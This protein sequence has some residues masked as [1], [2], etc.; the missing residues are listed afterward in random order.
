MNKLDKAIKNAML[1]YPTVYPTRE[2]FLS[3]VFLVIGNGYDWNN[4][5]LVSYGDIR[6]FKNR[7]EFVSDI[8]KRITHAIEQSDKRIKEYN[9][10]SD[11]FD[12]L[13]EETLKKVTDRE[14]ERLAERLEDLQ[15]ELKT[16]YDMFDNIK[17]YVAAQATEYKNPGY[18][19]MNICKPY[20]KICNIPDDIEESW[21]DGAIEIAELLLPVNPNFEQILIELNAKKK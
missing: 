13:D 16:R 11:P 19:E 8:D 6:V 3:H 15:D 9:D 7:E 12:K 20:A 14:A 10:E 5:V 18:Y 1:T 21:L 2:R 17:K 4:G